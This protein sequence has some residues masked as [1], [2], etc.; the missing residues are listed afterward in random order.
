M[1]K[2]KICL[3]RKV[4]YG[5]IYY[6][7]NCKDSEYILSLIKSGARDRAAFKEKEVVG[8]VNLG[9]ELDISTENEV[10]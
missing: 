10:V 9:W 4:N 2:V 6:Y 7:P 3:I 1:C 8:M 5:R